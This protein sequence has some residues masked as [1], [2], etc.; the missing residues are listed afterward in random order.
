LPDRKPAVLVVALACAVSFW[1]CAG[2]EGAR[3]QPAAPASPTAA[4]P[5]L[6]P[7]Q[8]TALLADL[9]V[10]VQPIFVTKCAECHGLDARGGPAAPNILELDEKHTPE[11][12]IAYLKNPQSRN[13][14]MP[15]IVATQ[16]EYRVLGEWLAITTAKASGAGEE[17]K[18]GEKGTGGR[19]A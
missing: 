17:R 4:A 8:E 1:A 18:R 12:W 19:K 11:Q 7:S 15:R 16:E 3:N 14:K 9:P 10:D 6:S 5:A 13:K 2:R